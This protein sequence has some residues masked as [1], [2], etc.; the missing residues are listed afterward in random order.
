MVTQKSDL[1]ETD[2]A[3]AHNMEYDRI[4]TL[5]LLMELISIVDKR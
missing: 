1:P 2:H 3:K 4:V 5:G